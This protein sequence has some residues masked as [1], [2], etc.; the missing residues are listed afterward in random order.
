[1]AATNFDEY[2]SAMVEES[3]HAVILDWY[4]RLEL[5]I[6]AY[7]GSR[8]IHYAQGKRAE[9]IIGR[10]P[11]LG[12]SVA[13]KLA[14]LRKLRNTVAHTPDPVPTETAVAFA[15]DCFSFIGDLGKAQDAHP[16]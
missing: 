16:A 10:D 3:P 9:S 4:R 2:V 13:S 5:A 8:H 15:R 14:A 12:V 1:M 6:N 11:L 7:I